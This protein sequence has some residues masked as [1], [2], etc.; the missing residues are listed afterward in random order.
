[1]CELEVVGY[2]VSKNSCLCLDNAFFRA[3]I[4][5]I[6]FGSAS[7]EIGAVL[8]QHQHFG[9]IDNFYIRD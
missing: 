1:M 6:T 8:I 9:G 4:F 5:C 2:P 3:R 7:V